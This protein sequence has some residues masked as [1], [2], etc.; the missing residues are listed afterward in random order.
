[1]V[2]NR[3]TL[4]HL[5]ET[6]VIDL[7][8]ADLFDRPPEPPPSC[9]G[10]DRIEGM[11]LGLA[12]GDSLGA[13]SESMAPA[14]RRAVFGEVRDYLPRRWS[15]DDARGFPTDDTQLA[16]WTL[17]QMIE[18]RGF[19]PERLAR[20]FAGGRIYGIGG[21]VRSFLGNYHAGG[22]PWFRCGPASAGNGALMRIAPMVIPHVKTG[23]ADLWVDTALSAM[24]T[25]N[26]SGS[27]AACLAFVDILWRLLAMDAPPEPGWWVERYVE[28]ARALEQGTYRPRGGVDLDFEGPIWRFVQERV[29]AAYDKGLSTLE[30][31]EGWHSG[32]FLLETV[33]CVLYILMRHGDDPEEA[34]VRAVNDTL[35]N[36]TIA[37]IVGAAV[38]ALHGRQGLPARWIRDL[39]GRTREDD[40]GR[41]FEL[42]EQT[43][44]LW[45]DAREGRRE[46]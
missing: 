40:D 35:D 6:G 17:E 45:W 24:M 14:E 4:E 38:G 29:P 8:R 30:A 15:G 36:D 3:K 12:V 41:V 13:P 31:C 21:T 11:M 33:P 25:H 37:A 27:T 46:E 9:R 34:I 5:F 32:A 23:G 10:F 26:D 44:A 43:R 16:F 18:D 7:R 28:T 2:T 39:T 20:K 19:V 1:M 22:L 42:L